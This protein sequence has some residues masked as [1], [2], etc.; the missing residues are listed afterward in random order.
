MKS[1]SKA[2]LDLED[3]ST[4]SASSLESKL[5]FCNGDESFV[6]RSTKL[7]PP[8]KKPAISSIPQSQFLGKVKDFLGVISEAN[9]TLEL[10]AKTNPGK[11]YDIEALTGEES[12]Y[13]EMDLMLGVA[14][15]QTE[16]AVAAAESA[17]SGYQPVIPL[18]VSSSETESE[19]SSDDEDSEDSD[20]D[21]DEA[22]RPF[23]KKGKTANPVEKDSSSSEASKNKQQPRKRP[24]IVELS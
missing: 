18:A 7:N 5:S 1:N 9:K 21:D 20:G 11:K 23:P 17:L 6:S 24:K 12:E 4:P 16:E 8:D 22:E 10:D 3:K 15:L 13:I 19:E 14:E 2:L